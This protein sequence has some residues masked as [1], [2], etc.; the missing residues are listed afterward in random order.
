M[1]FCIK[2]FHSSLQSIHLPRRQL[3]LNRNIRKFK[4]RNTLSKSSG[5]DEP[6]SPEASKD[7]NDVNVLSPLKSSTTLET[8]SPDKTQ[9]IEE[10]NKAEE[11]TGATNETIPSTRYFLKFYVKI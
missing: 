10:S 1:L 9:N 6:S 8:A 5:C 3:F 11:I 2:I 4:L 7:L